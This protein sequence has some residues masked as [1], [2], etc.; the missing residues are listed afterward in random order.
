MSD[1]MLP[2]PFVV[3]QKYFDRTGEYLVTATDEH[4]V[5]IERTDGHRTI[6]DVAIKA[7]IHRNVLMERHTHVTGDPTHSTM[8]RR[9]PTKRRQH[10]MEKILQLE[11]DGADHKGVEIDRFLANIA[12]DLGYSANDLSDLHATGRSVFANDGDWAKAEMTAD[13]LHEVVGEAAYWDAGVRRR[14][15][16][17]RITSRGL[18]E[19]RSR[20]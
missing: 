17:Y 11:A 16:V 6:E 8:K 5:T 4:K 20:R 10:L 2:P 1:D 19:L 7:R 15:N 14:C 12:G 9:K 3:G 13:R 18:D